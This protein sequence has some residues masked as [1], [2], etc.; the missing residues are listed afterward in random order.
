MSY[1]SCKV[2]QKRV[3][4][5]AADY[6][7]ECTKGDGSKVQICVKGQTINENQAKQLCQNGD[8]DSISDCAHW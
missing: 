5:T 4:A 1:S 7:F 3:G 8:F 6:K 2:L